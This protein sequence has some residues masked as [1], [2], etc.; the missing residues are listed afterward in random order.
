MGHRSIAAFDLRKDFGKLTFGRSHDSVAVLLENGL[1]CL[2]AYV[3]VGAGP[4]SI[5]RMFSAVATIANGAALFSGDYGEVAVLSWLLAKLMENPTDAS[6]APDTIL[7]ACRKDHRL[8]AL[9]PSQMPDARL[10][11][12]PRLSQITSDPASAEAASKRISAG[13]GAAHEVRNLI[14]QH[15]PQAQLPKKISV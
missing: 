1:V 15:F 6:Q 13:L 4:G 11:L 7:E 10:M 9:L 3:T 8:V 5:P 14:K 12:R 2:D